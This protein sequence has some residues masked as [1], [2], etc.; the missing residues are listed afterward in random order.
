MSVRLQPEDFDVSAEVAS[1]TRGRTDI[2]AVVNFIGIC[3]AGPD[4]DRISAM[5]LDHY[6]EM[7]QAE[8]ERIEAEARERWPLQGVA[9]IH[10]HGRLVPG[11][12][13]VLVVTAS[14]H[15]QAAFEAASF[16]MDYLKTRAPFWKKEERASGTGWVAAKDE[17]DAAA[18][19]WATKKP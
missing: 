12:N 2:G 13:I 10:R 7:A 4:D 17:D 9:I 19:R 1:L 14:M 8:F 15:R 18:A 16:L 11:D 5:T 6:P 3:R